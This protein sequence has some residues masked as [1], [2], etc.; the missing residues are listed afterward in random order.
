MDDLEILASSRARVKG[1]ERGGNRTYGRARLVTALLFLVCL[2]SFPCL[3]F[4]VLAGGIAPL[5]VM[6][7]ATVLA[8]ISPGSDDFGLVLGLLS[9]ANVAVW[10]TAVFAACRR[11]V[12]AIYA[13]FT[14]SG[15]I[16]AGALLLAVAA[17]GLL[18]FYWVGGHGTPVGKNAYALFFQ[19]F[20]S[21]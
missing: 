17:L 6:A 21:G 18:P 3:Y 5:S 14:T 16:V 11:S 10:G 7:G 4:L 13:R 9:L 20:T 19:I 12:R 8:F 2:F 15:D 1:R